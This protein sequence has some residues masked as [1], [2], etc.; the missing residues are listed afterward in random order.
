MPRS[1][2]T[3]RLCLFVTLAFP[4]LPSDSLRAQDRPL[5]WDDL[6]EVWRV[7]G[8]AA[9]LWAQFTRPDDMASPQPATTRPRC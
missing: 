7:G 8:L 9:P 6:A 3:V 5:A 1:R 2:M 4:V